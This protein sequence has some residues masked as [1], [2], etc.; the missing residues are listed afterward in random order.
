MTAEEVFR[1]FYFSLVDV[2]AAKSVGLLPD[3]RRE[4][5]RLRTHYRSI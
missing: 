4:I 3:S 5:A 1:V 2:V